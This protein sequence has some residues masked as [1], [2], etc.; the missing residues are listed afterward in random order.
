VTTL[1]PHHDDRVG[2]AFL[3]SDRQS[4]VSW[5]EFYRSTLLTKIGGLTS[6]QVCRRAVPP[7]TLTLLGIVR[8]LTK[9][10]RYWFGNVVAGLDRPRLYCEVDPE[11][12][13]AGARP[14]NALADLDRYHAEVVTA[15][16]R[17][18]A[19]PDLDAALPGKRHGEEINLRW[20]LVHMIEE[21][22]RHLGHADLLRECI[23]GRTGY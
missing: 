7:S 13:F 1:L 10:E 23:D 20:I 15:R 8:H 11:G 14:E 6:D 21:Y 16:E 4:L 17:A 12:D 2:P 22:A 9:V 18:S 5:L 3:E 19:V